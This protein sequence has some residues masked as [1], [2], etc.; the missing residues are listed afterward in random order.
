MRLMALSIS[1][2]AK[3]HIF[4]CMPRDPRA[5]FVTRFPGF[6]NYHSRNQLFMASWLPAMTVISKLPC[7]MPPEIAMH[8]LITLGILAVGILA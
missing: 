6:H 5:H 7:D 1:H 3:P 8:A 2:Q 4:L